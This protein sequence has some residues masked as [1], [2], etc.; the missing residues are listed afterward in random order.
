[1]LRRSKA[2]EHQ[3]SAAG[4]DCTLDHRPVVS[5]GFPALIELADQQ[6]GR[7]LLPV[8]RDLRRGG[9]QSVEY[10]EGVALPLPGRLP[11]IESSSLPQR[12]EKLIERD[13]PH[14]RNVFR[15]ARARASNRWRLRWDCKSEW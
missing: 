11:L 4:A 8:D 14:T 1:M 7:Q 10:S 13:T 2:A 6:V 15:P 3:N 5:V 12:D 9:T